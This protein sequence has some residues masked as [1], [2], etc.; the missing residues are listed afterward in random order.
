MKFRYTIIKNPF[1][2]INKQ[3]SEWK[4]GS[5][6]YI[7]PYYRFSFCFVRLT[8]NISGLNYKETIKNR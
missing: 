2:I 5:K 6:I 4:N 3:V 8:L 7:W 1:K